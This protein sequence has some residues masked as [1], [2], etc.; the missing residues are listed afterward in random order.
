M[1]AVQVFVMKKDQQII[2]LSFAKPVIETSGKE[3][4]IGFGR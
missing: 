2:D 3:S 4:Y 1:A